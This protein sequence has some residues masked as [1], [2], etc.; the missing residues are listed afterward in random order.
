VCG[1]RPGA[2]LLGRYARRAEG[3]AFLPGGCCAMV[4]TSPMGGHGSRGHQKASRSQWGRPTE[5]NM[6]WLTDAQAPYGTGKG[7]PRP[8]FAE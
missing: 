7:A 6:P 2:F 1:K 4:S 3:G 5:G 8:D